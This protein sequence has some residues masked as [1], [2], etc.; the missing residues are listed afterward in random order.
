MKASDRYLKIVEWSAEDGAYVGSAPGLVD[1]CCHGDDEAAVYKELCQIVEEW[2]E[3]Y[4]KEGM[5]LPEPTAGKTYSGKFVVRVPPEL[6]KALTIRAL[7]RGESLN[8]F[9]KKTLEKAV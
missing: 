4:K 7:Q 9:C 1:A 5:P 3:I 6:H 2:I 8:S